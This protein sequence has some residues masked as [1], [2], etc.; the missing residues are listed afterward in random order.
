MIFDDVIV[1][2]GSSGVVLAARLSEDPSRQVLLIE[3]GPD[4]R[5][6]DEHAR[7][8]PLRPGLAGRSRLGLHRRGDRR[9][10]H[11]VS[12]GQGRR[13][14][15]GGERDHRAA[16]RPGRLRRMGGARTARM[17]LGR[18]APF[19]RARRRRPRRLRHRSQPAPH[20]WRVAHRPRRVECLATLSRR[21]PRR[22]LARTV[23]QRV[24][25]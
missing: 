12:P 19:Y 23:S 3:S 15:V 11:P 14:F 4:Y 25:T 10:H 24:R 22:V 7:R 20:R 6:I 16:G 8:P 18:S 17:G 5:S 21:V 1:G 13:W 9:P 2:A